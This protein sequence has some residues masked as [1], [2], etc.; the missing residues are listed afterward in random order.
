MYQSN[1]EFIGWDELL[2]VWAPRV[3]GAAVILIAAWFIGKAL[4]WALARGIDR[5]PG[6]NRHNEGLDRRQTVGAKLGE[7][8]FWLVLL[9]GVV[10]A[11][12]ALQLGPI[13]TPLN[14]LLSDIFT[15]VPN[16]IGAALIFF[17]GFLVATIA[18]RLV[19][20]AL[21]AVNLDGVFRRA[22]IG[23][24]PSSTVISNALGTLVFVLI[25]IPVAIA[26]LQTLQ[27]AAISDPAVSVL[28]TV[29]NAI[30]NVLA[31]AIVLAIGTLIGRW[32]ASVVERVLPATGFDRAIGGLGAFSSLKAKSDGAAVQPPLF[33]QGADPMA[34]PPAVTAPATP[35]KIVANLVLFAIIAF[36]AIEAARMLQFAAIAGILEDILGLAGRIVVGGVIITAAVLIADMLA[37][38]IDRSTNNADGFA[39]VIVKWATIALGTAM[40]LRFMGIADEIVILAFGLILGSAAVAVALSFGLGGREAAGRL[41]SRWVEKAQQPRP[42]KPPREPDDRSEPRVFP[43]NAADRFQ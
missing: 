20:T 34:P 18:K 27:I 37:N 39:S 33:D 43:E 35:S 5:L 22:G 28:T 25:L 13:V 9:F 3:L 12:T 38:A 7:V 23:G 42:P 6:A 36:S 4:K 10:G 17:V 40:G 15:Y 30:P 31:A 24:A 2:G 8:A 19:T 21:Q 26:A 1:Y 14:A 32:I 11:L 41:A 16:V 29:L